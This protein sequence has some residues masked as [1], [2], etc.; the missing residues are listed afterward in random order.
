VLAQLQRRPLDSLSAPS[1][2][3]R[4]ADLA[5]FAV[6]HHLTPLDGLDVL[7]ETREVTGAT[8]ARLASALG[9]HEEAALITAREPSRPET[10]RWTGTCGGN[11]VCRAASATIAAST[12]IT[13]DVAVVQS[14]EIPPYVEI[15]VDDERLAEGPIDGARRFTMPVRAAGPHRV[16]VRLINPQTRNRFQRRIRLS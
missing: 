16:E 15:Y 4:A 14:D 10:A 11:D 9:R 1:V 12:E 2:A 8:R 3:E 6:R 7:V 13:L 5:E